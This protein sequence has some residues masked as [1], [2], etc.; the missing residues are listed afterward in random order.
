MLIIFGSMLAVAVIVLIATM[1]AKDS[2]YNNAISFFEEEN[3]IA[4]QAAF[5]ELG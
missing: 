1:I 4:S 2:R 5:E 3:Y